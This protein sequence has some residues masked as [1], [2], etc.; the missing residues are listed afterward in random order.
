[1]S[2]SRRFLDSLVPFSVHN[3]EPSVTCGL[4]N[5]CDTFETPMLRRET[6]PSPL[7]AGQF[8][9]SDV[10][11]VSRAHYESSDGRNEREE[12]SLLLCGRDVAAA[13]SFCFHCLLHPSTSIFVLEVWVKSWNVGRN[14]QFRSP[15]VSH[16]RGGT[17]SS[18]CS[19]CLCQIGGN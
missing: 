19:G 16:F 17:N 14:D 10:I 9:Y 2:P 8:P 3:T 6:R 11:S 1:M 13:G 4:F 18:N 7:D 5:A 12:K 15:A